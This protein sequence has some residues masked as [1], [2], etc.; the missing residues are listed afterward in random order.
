MAANTIP[1]PRRLTRPSN[2][3]MDLTIAPRG[4]CGG[5][6]ATSWAETKSEPAHQS[7][8]EL[9]LLQAG[10]Q[11][12]GRRRRHAQ[13]PR[14]GALEELWSKT[15]QVTDMHMQKQ[16]SSVPRN[17]YLHS[18]PCNHT[19]AQQSCH[20]S[21]APRRPQLG[22]RPPVTCRGV[23]DGLCQH[24]RR[25]GA[26][27]WSFMSRAVRRRVHRINQ[28]PHPK[29]YRAG[30]RVGRGETGQHEICNSMWR[31]AQLQI[32]TSESNSTDN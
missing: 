23:R 16:N 10:Q 24:V 18:G 1:R 8:E 11:R 4:F 15:N 21:L 32:Q 31:R 29:K 17:K 19:R 20:L 2:T 3:N 12:Q 27:P 30:I 25:L 26:I 7:L 6:Y 9:H 28:H 14:A 5:Q 22:L 13:P